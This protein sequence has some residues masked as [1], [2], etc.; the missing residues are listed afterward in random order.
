MTS[1]IKPDVHITS[2][3][4]E[5]WA[6]AIGN[7]YKQHSC[8]IAKITAWCALYM[9]ALTVLG[10]PYYRSSLW[11]DVSS[12]VCLSVVCDVLYCDKTVRPSKKVSEGVNR[13][14]GSKSSF[15]GVAAIFLLPVSPLRPLR[16]PFLPYFCPYSQAIGT[17][18]YK[19][20][21][22][23]QTMCVFSDGVFRIETGSSFSHDYW[24]R[25]V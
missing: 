7:M 4:D 10:R 8:A 14:P 19:L 9:S 24:P 17:R 1:S 6:M 5:D 11:H 25:K 18:W 2:P 15:W 23:Q 22:W 20:T 12:V 13:K 21:F 16:R 3:S